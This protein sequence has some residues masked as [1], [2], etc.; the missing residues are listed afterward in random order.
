MLPS[1]SSLPAALLLSALL[2]AA[3]SPQVFKDDIARF[4]TGVDQ[5]T[6]A[7]DG[8]RR[9]NQQLA[10]AR[11]NDR[12][13]RQGVHIGVVDDDAC[14]ETTFDKLQADSRCLAE[15][16]SFRAGRGAA[17]SCS[18]PARDASGGPDFYDLAAVGAAETRACELGVVSEGAA[19][20][21]SLAVVAPLANVARLN[22]G[23]RAY[24]A[25]LASIADGK[26]EQALQSAT[27]DARNALTKAANEIKSLSGADSTGF[28]AVGPLSDLVGEALFVALEEH[29]YLVLRRVVGTAD[30]IIDRSARIISRSAMPL[31]LPKLREDGTTLRKAIETFN[32][33]PAGADWITAL[34][35]AQKAQAA[36]LA[37]YD[38][39]PTVALAAMADAHHAL[40]LAL[41]DPKREI[42]PLKTAIVD[43]ATKAKAAH[44]VFAD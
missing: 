5:S 6:A 14:A 4:K 28:A 33:N 19:R 37:D 43:F 15:W 8:L 22:D 32:N 10:V 34:A 20:S 7:F 24:A 30:P 25:A 12:L 29:R 40:K 38:A 21:G 26:D 44:D 2:A 17:P 9:G 11:L 36:Y 3:C 39:S 31:L 18:E 16:A 27:A 41:D 1:S 35:K 13:S 42:E 23:L